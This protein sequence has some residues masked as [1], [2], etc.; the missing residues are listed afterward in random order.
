V[1]AN[2]REIMLALA[3]PPTLLHAVAS[4]QI[5]LQDAPRTAAVTTHPTG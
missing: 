1:N 2:N 4:P 3:S 5:M